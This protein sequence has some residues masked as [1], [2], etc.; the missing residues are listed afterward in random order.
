M[1]VAQEADAAF[2]CRGAGLAEE[3]GANAGE[4]DTN[5][6]DSSAKA[7]GGAEEYYHGLSQRVKYVPVSL[8]GLAVC[9]IAARWEM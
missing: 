5:D 8:Y 9:N 1:L 6:V 3:C 4:R 7:G 2:E